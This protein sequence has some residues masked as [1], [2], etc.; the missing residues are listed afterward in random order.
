MRN[1]LAM[2]AALAVAPLGLG[3]A[4]A[5]EVGTEVTLRGCLV[6]EEE[7]GEEVEYLLEGVPE[8]QSAADEI[9]LA[10]GE[11]VEFAPHVGHTVEVTG[12]VTAD[13]DEADEEESGEE[14]SEEEGEGYREI[15]VQ[16]SGL[17]HIAASC[18][19]GGR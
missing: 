17:Q 3:A 5:Q 12:R 6:Q 19:E 10:A 8:E 7:A 15:V 16:A 2:L 1:L 11:G 14:E 18:E 9:E 13:E 4:H